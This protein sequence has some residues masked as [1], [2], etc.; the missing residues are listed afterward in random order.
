MRI[1]TTTL[2]YPRP[3][4]PD[5]GIFVQRRALA[6]AGLPAGATDSADPRVGI[7]VVSPILWCPLLRRALRASS[8]PGPL[9]VVYPKML[10]VPVVGWATDG[11]AFARALRR[12]I[13]SMGPDHGIDLIDAHFEFPDGVGAWLA[14]RRLGLP[15]VVTVRGK[16]I[17]LSRRAIRRLQIRAMLRGVDARIA[18]SESLAAQV[19]RV[20]GSDLHV[21]V[22]P[23][24]VDAGVFHP[25]ERGRARSILG[26]DSSARYVLAVGHLQ[27]LKGFDRIVSVMP[28]VREALGDVRLVLAGSRRGERRFRRRLQRL[29]D[30]VNAHRPLPG[31]GPTVRF[32]G[33]VDSPQLNL[34]Y[35]AA[36][37]LVNASRHEGW[38]NVISEALAAGTP[39]VA[40]DVGGNPEQISSPV[41]GTLVPEGDQDALTRAII[42]A[43]CRGWS[44]AGI[45]AHGA[46]RTWTD[47]AREVR[48]VFIRVIETRRAGDLCP[49]IE[50]ALE[51]AP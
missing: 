7:Q 39:V 21:D 18:V 36:D 8:Q 28:T 14:G 12:T 32:V 49:R 16:I 10:S 31:R 9:P 30:D 17:S 23:N 35:N 41:V 20:A 1:L 3:D 22:V 50:P 5:Q 2:C 24:G 4:E 6:L 29:I 15:V 47:V 51:V 11:L 42:G 25:V 34:M 27:R 26:W 38:N 46:C 40:T 44:C 13:R 19:R 37:L 45:A 43:L 48:A 33:P